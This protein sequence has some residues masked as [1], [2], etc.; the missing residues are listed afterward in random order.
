MLNRFFKTFILSNIILVA[1]TSICLGSWQPNEDYIPSSP[2]IKNIASLTNEDNNF[3]GRIYFVERNLNGK[4]ISVLSLE[5]NYHML[6]YGSPSD[7]KDGLPRYLGENIKGEFITN[8]DFKDEFK[9]VGNGTIEEQN[10][11]FQPWRNSEVHNWMTNHGEKNFAANF[12]YDGNKVF[13]PHIVKGLQ[14]KRGDSFLNST[15]R[16]WTQYVHIIQPPTY[17]GWGM[18]RMWHKEGNSI[19][20]ISVPLAPDAEIRRW[21]P[22]LA[23]KSL[24]PGTPTDV[25]KTTGQ[26]V[27]L[28]TPGHT[29]EAT[30]VFKVESMQEGEQDWPLS[31]SF[32][33]AMQQVSTGHYMAQLQKVSGNGLISKIQSRY[34]HL[35]TP[36]Q[37][38]V[39]NQK[40]GEIVARFK[41]TA[42]KNTKNLVAVINNDYFANNPIYC[43][44][45]HWEGLTKTQFE[46]NQMIVPIKLPPDVFVKSITASTKT[47]KAGE[48]Y[49]GHVAFGLDG[50]YDRP[51]K[52]EI[53]LTH[54]NSPI[55][56]IHKEMLT[57]NPGE[58]KSFNFNF[59]GQNGTSILEAKI[60]P[61]EPTEQDA[62][63]SNNKSKLTITQDITDIAVVNLSQTVP[64]R[65][66][67]KPIANVMFK[68][69]GTKTETFV[70]KYYAD[71]VVVKTEEISIPKGGNVYRAFNWDAPSQ[72]KNVELKVEADPN[73]L[74]PDINRGNNV[75][76][77]NVKV[78]AYPL[79][80]ASCND[81][82]SKTSGSWTKHYSRLVGYN[83]DG[84]EKWENY[85][86]TYTEELSASIRLNT[87][88][89]IPTDPKD[90]KA[91]DRESRG[92]WEIIPWAAKHGLQ[93]NKVTRAGYGIELEVTTTYW[94]SYQGIE[95]KL[96]GPTKVTAE[97]FDT[98]NR[99]AGI[100]DLVPTH[101]ERGDK[102]I[103]WALPQQEFTYSDGTKI[104]ERKHYTKVDIPDGKYYVVIYMDG[105]GYS[106]LK[107]CE[108]DFVVI[109]GD[110][111]DDINTKPIKK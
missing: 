95:I 67:T 29:Y 82:T 23:V 37:S 25:D 106:G 79:P 17:Y 90:P 102:N 107:L 86:V 31:P 59:T 16:D 10:W 92:S 55:Q 3:L 57:L 63:W 84:T 93:A 22:N 35:A 105:I 89:G 76:I 5:K 39:F 97:F 19:R 15:P 9:F 30:V 66:G 62:N 11:L 2:T 74:L 88:Q 81:K 36:G 4:S 65:V 7:Y 43:K 42:Q 111:Y 101:G 12:P 98:N 53:E 49:T 33:T 46:D 61:K 32:I 1:I 94:T 51:V 68:N 71:N 96:R 69:L 54:N 75:A 72:A 83:A 103:T 77:K 40:N 60:R 24:I 38:I 100:V 58:I 6:F 109:H 47:T 41:W 48:K 13:L 21:I 28:A 18:G 52:A 99:S 70:A 78:E 110:M 14:L 44:R 104:Q 56:G 34:P 8:P 50:Y 91:S 85:S 108:E 64:I 27:Y 80:P 26:A 73:H 45:L 20:Y 87:K